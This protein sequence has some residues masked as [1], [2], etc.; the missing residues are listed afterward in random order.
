MR[1]K[2]GKMWQLGFVLVT[3]AVSLAI[4]NLAWATPT[5]AGGVAYDTLCYDSGVPMPPD[6]LPKGATNYWTLN[7]LP[8]GDGSISSTQSFT[9]E[10]RYIYYYV[11]PGN[12]VPFDGKP[13]INPPGL[14]MV[15]AGTTTLGIAEINVL[16]QGSNGKTCFW[17][18][19]GFPEISPAFLPAGPFPVPQGQFKASPRI[20]SRNPKD[21]EAPGVFGPGDTG[22]ASACNTTTGAN[23]TRFFAGGSEHGF[24]DATTA[25]NNNTSVPI[26]CTNCH[27]GENMII[28]HPGTA[29]DI[30]GALNSAEDQ[31]YFPTL[32]G[33]ANWPDPLVP[34]YTAGLAACGSGTST[35][36]GDKTGPPVT[37]SCVYF[38]PFNP[39]PSDY[40]TSYST[41]LAGS[42]CFKCHQKAANGLT[43]AGR[44]PWISAALG[45][46][47]IVFNSGSANQ[48]YT[49]TVFYPSVDRPM[50][51]PATGCTVSTCDGAMPKNESKGQ[52]ALISGDPFALEVLNDD[53]QW[54]ADA[55]SA[56]YGGNGH[57]GYLFP[58][59]GSGGTYVSAYGT[60]L[61]YSSSYTQLESTSTHFCWVSGIEVVTQLVQPSPVERMSLQVVNGYWELVGQNNEGG[62]I[63]AQ[64]APWA[65]FFG[66]QLTGYNAR[67]LT[68]TTV[69][70]SYYTYTYGVDGL[71]AKEPVAIPQSSTSGLCFI[72]GFGGAFVTNYDTTQ[73][74]AT[75]WWPGETTP[76]SYSAI[77]GDGEHWFV[78][79][80]NSSTQ[81]FLDVNISCLDI[82][83][84]DPIDVFNPL[85]PPPYPN[86]AFGNI[87]ADW[88]S[89]GRVNVYA[90]SPEYGEGAT[91]PIFGNACFYTQIVATGDQGGCYGDVATSEMDANYFTKN[92]GYQ[93]KNSTES[94]L[95]DGPS[96][97]YGTYVINESYPF[98]GE[99]C[100]TDVVWLA[101]ACLQAIP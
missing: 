101:Q 98:S 9:G 2:I 10:Q 17:R 61:S 3:I 23:C 39:G 1:A 14:C 35:G 97:L 4:P 69:M 11:S 33:D 73:A 67:G 30:T 58:Q 55:Q 19:P 89:A 59:T 45:P 66:S 64:C 46:G 100:N 62:T 44:L 95:Y 40:S 42:G 85:A 83:L 22:S 15:N 43:Y 29:T 90:S 75:L 76:N 13:G 12:Q 24:N 77:G 48:G 82:G 18:W 16:C 20:S 31:D 92:G 74:A 60:T 79:Q 86:D 53:G 37:G 68:P 54:L 41:N 84:L 49:N 70:Q 25:G 96:T 38:P 78:Q 94:G 81:S 50:P 99:V 7:K 91:A 72:S 63:N 26:A 80:S 52:S 87:F 28:N 8:M 47:D 5:S 6:F 27:V 65:A 21:F 51:G 93:Y 71:P 88:Q 36:T 56:N 34:A 32:G 57:S